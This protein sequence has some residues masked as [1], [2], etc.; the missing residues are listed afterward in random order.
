MLLQDEELDIL[1]HQL[2]RKFIAYARIYVHPTLSKEAAEIIK[3]F[4]LDLRKNYHTANNIP[5]TTRQLQSLIRLTQ[6]N[7]K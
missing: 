5:V 6:V 3:T 7:K 2:L 4:Y 1:P